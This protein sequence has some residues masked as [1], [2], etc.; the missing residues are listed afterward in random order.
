[1]CLELLRKLIFGSAPAAGHHAA[2]AAEAGAR[3]KGY[4]QADDFEIDTNIDL[5]EKR[6]VVSDEEAEAAGSKPSATRG[7]RPE[8]K[9]AASTKLEVQ[10]EAVQPHLEESRASDY[11]GQM[12]V[13]PVRI[14]RKIPQARKMKEKRVKTDVRYE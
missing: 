1:M 6:E 10:E 8:K 14:E 7:P 13:K 5:A 4:Q 9:L 11:F 3:Q 12:E 2:D